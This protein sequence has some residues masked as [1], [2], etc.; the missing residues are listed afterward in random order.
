MRCIA[1]L[2]I[3]DC[4]VGYIRVHYVVK[5]NLLDRG[6]QTSLQPDQHVP[7]GHAATMTPWPSYYM[8]TSC[9]CLVTH[10]LHITEVDRNLLSSHFDGLIIEYKTPLQNVVS[11]LWWVGGDNW[12]Q[13][14]I[15]LF[16]FQGKLIETISGKPADDSQEVLL[17]KVNSS[18]ILDLIAS[19]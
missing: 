13:H 12:T 10:D 9:A 17:K 8:C 18:R 7:Y 11:P 1:G 14:L 6:G 3:I 2:V 5:T 19:R 16:F 15:L 4:V